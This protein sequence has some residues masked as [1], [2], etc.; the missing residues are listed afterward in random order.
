MKEEVVKTNQQVY[1]SQSDID[2]DDL[3]KICSQKTLQED[4]PFADSVSNNVVIYD[5]NYLETFIG[6]SENELRLKTELHQ[7]LE[8]GPGVF[9]I[10]NLYR[11]DAI[12]QSNNIFEKIVES[13][14]NTSNDHFASGTNTRIWN[15]FQKV[16]LEDPNAFISYYSN[17][18]LKLVAE[19][20][21]GP[22]SQMTAQVN[23]VRP[24]GEMQK[25]HRDYH[26]GFQENQIVELFPISAHRLSNY[27]TLQGGVAHTDMPL[28]SGP[29]MV[30]PY[31]QQY[32]LGYLAWRDNACTDFFNDNAVQNQM[33]KGDG[34]FFN[35][36]L[37]HGA[38]SNTTKDFHRI[39][40]LLQISSPFGKTMERIDYLKIIN[41]IYPLLLE[42]SINKTLSEKLIENVLVCATDGYAFPT[43]LDNDK[44]SNSKLQGMTMFELTKQSLLDLVNLENFSLKL[45]EHQKIRFTN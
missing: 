14:G 28:A 6:D 5:A 24:G 26:L 8:G 42:H 18:L 4:Y 38:G 17:N 16:A 15:A 3:A 35:P 7:V 40:N 27:L 21:C 10:R 39:G 1:F 32:E 2:Y 13:E 30:L 25:P 12:D 31:S 34:I 44:N 41:R 43:N 9:V 22:N 19:S 36:A 20:W 29:T 33:N 37:L 45:L 23:I 11:H